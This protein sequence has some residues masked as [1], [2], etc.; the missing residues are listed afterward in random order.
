MIRVPSIAAVN[1]DIRTQ[2][3]TQILVATFRDKIRQ[4]ANGMIRLLTKNRLRWE[5]FA[6]Q[7]DDSDMEEP[8][9]G[10]DLPVCVLGAYFSMRSTAREG[11][12]R[13]ALEQGGG[14]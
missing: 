1:Y 14:V 4:P 3:P 8:Q 11:T 5:F 6:A 12:W 7:D 9:D 13:E 2:L 10:G